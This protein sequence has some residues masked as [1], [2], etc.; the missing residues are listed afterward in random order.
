MDLPQNQDPR[1][2]ENIPSF[3]L[4]ELNKGLTALANL[5]CADDDGIVV[6]ILKHGS[7]LLKDTLLKHFK[8]HT[9]DIED[10]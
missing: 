3:T 6:E 2:L 4:D 1:I 7:Q 9:G 10:S 8:L 5:R